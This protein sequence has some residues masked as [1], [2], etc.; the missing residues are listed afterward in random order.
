VNKTG[1]DS[2]NLNGTDVTNTPDTLGSLVLVGDQFQLT[3]PIDVVTLLTVSGF[4]IP[5]VASGE[6][7]AFAPVP[8]PSTAML[9]TIGGALAAVAI[10]R[11]K[12]RK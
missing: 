5:L 2:F 4:E 11:A 7:V 1:S 12:P 10:L 8:E 9:L 6:V 3:T